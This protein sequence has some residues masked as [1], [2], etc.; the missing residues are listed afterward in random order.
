MKEHPENHNPFFEAVITEREVVGREEQPSVL[1]DFEIS[2]FLQFLWEQTQEHW[3][4]AG[5]HLPCSTPV[6]NVP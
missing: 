6:H 3:K 1:K 2:N 5:I 4:N